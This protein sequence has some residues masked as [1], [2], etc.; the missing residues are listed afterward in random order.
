MRAASCEFRRF[1]EFYQEQSNRQK[2]GY[3]QIQ[4]QLIT[5][6]PTIYVRFELVAIHAGKCWQSKKKKAAGEQWT[7]I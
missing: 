7:I 4:M 1:S 6:C 2:S 3:G 5:S